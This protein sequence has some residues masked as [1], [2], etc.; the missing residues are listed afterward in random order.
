MPFLHTVENLPITCSRPSIFMVPLYLWFAS[1]GLTTHRSCSTIVL[2]IGKNPRVSEPTQFKPMFV[3]G[4]L[5]KK[6]ANHKK[7]A[8]SDVTSDT[9]DFRPKDKTLEQ[10]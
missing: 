2:T 5:Y 3:R 7:V 9:V 4:Q 10:G 8:V 6:N 1:V